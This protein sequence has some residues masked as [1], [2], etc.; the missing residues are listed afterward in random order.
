MF[1]F[2]KRI[3]GGSSFSSDFSGPGKLYHML[4]PSNVCLKKCLFISAQVYTTATQVVV[5]NEGYTGEQEDLPGVTV[6]IGKEMVLTRYVVSEDGETTHGFKFNNLDPDTKD[7]FSI[8]SLEFEADHTAEEFALAVGFSLHCE[9]HPPSSFSPA[10][11]YTLIETEEANT[12]TPLTP[13]QLSLLAKTTLNLP[14]RALQGGPVIEH[15]DEDVTQLEG[16]IASQRLLD[17]VAGLY[18]DDQVLY[19]SPVELK[20]YQPDQD[21]LVPTVT[22]ALLLLVRNEARVFSLDVVEDGQLLMRTV[23][24]AEFQYQLGKTDQRLSWV[25]ASEAAVECWVAFTRRPVEPL[26]P[27]LARVLFDVVN[28]D[29]MSEVYEREDVDWLEGVEVTEGAL[30]QRRSLGVRMRA[31]LED[32]KVSEFAQHGDCVVVAKEEGLTV[33]RAGEESFETAL[34]LSSLRASDGSRLQPTSLLSCTGTDQVLFLSPASSR[35]HTFNLDRGKVVQEWQTPAPIDTICFQD[36]DPTSLVIGANSKALFAFDARISGNRMVASKGY[37]SKQHFSAIAGTR[38]GG[39]CVGTKK[40][41][42]KLFKQVGQI[43]KTSFP[44]LGDAILSVD[45]TDDGCW[46]LAT[47]KTYLLLLCVSESNGTGFNLRLGK[48]KRHPKKLTL[49]PTDIAKHQIQELNFTPAKFNRGGDRDEEFIVTSTGNFLVIW[50]FAQL[51]RTVDSAHF[52]TC[53][54]VHPLPHSAVQTEFRDGLT[55]ELLLADPL[56]IHVQVLT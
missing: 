35:V 45:V 44:G 1:K 9:S 47:A 48:K 19:V 11:I 34:Q 8:L 50:D 7:M 53:Y 3:L 55:S 33:L 52:L 5:E 36:R 13:H 27:L 4:D 16:V 12:S 21:R 20:E 51:R 6:P 15:T 24:T 40:G 10:S 28:N 14:P 39:L 30:G 54:Q 37:A 31:E 26:G 25:H 18:T 41:E 43:A 22:S 23:I 17:E 2:L 38:V 49:L 56:S 29:A 32:Q 46:V 42:I